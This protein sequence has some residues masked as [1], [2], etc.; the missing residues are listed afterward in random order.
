MLLNVGEIKDENTKDL[1]ID[2]FKEKY[3]KYLLEVLVFIAIFFNQNITH[4]NDDKGQVCKLR[5]FAHYFFN[6]YFKVCILFF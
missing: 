5:Y 4:W 1:F 3:G 2:G 6:N